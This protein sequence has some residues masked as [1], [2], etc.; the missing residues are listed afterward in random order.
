MNE[1]TVTNRPLLILGMHR[2][3]TSCLTGCLEDAGLFLG[4]VNRAAGFNKKGNCENR[5]ARGF[6]EDVLVRLGGSWDRPP[7]VPV[8][9]TPEEETALRRIVGR[10]PPGSQWGLK[11]PRLLLLFEPWAAAVRPRM[12]GTFRHPLE[13]ARSLMSRGEA[14]GTPMAEEHAL[15]LW[16]I[17]NQRLLALHQAHSFPLIRFDQHP[18]DYRR[19]VIQI[20]Q[21]LGLPGNRP[22]SFLEIPLRHQSA[23]AAPPP[24]DLKDLWQALLSRAI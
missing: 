16:R 22:I 3:G 4:N 19:K 14:L 1:L 20:A 18:D 15:M 8:K 17:Y 23:E 11:D 12:V 10:Y 13:V 9:L 7:K 2:S 24:S 6:N 21:L 5:Q